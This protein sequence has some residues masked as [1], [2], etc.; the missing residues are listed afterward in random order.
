MTV[1]V[2]TFLRRGRTRLAALREDLTR[3][4]W[5]MAAVY[6]LAGFLLSA[7][8]LLGGP[9]PLAMALCGGATG[10]RSLAIALGSVAGSWAFWGSAGTESMV[11]AAIGCAAGLFLGKKRLSADCPWLIPGVLGA[12]VAVTGLVFQHFG[13][14]TGD[15]GSYLLTIVL[16]VGA[17]RLFA[18]A[19]KQP[20]AVTDWLI[21]GSAVLA[22]AQIV[23]LPGINLGCVAGGLLAVWGAFPGALLAGFALDLARISRVSMTAVLAL[24][25]LGRFVPKGNGWVRGTG[26]GLAYLLVA[27]L[28]GIWD[29]WP[30][31]CLALGGLLARCLP[32]KAR[33]LP[34]RGEIGVA[35]VRLEAAAQALGECGRLLSDGVEDTVDEAAL[36]EQCRTRACGDCPNRKGCGLDAL[37]ADLLHREIGDTGEL[38]LGCK[39]PGRLTLELRRSREQ[40]RA[41]EGRRRQMAECRDALAWQYDF[42]ARYLQNQSDLLRNR[43][44]RQR[45][46]FCP[47]VAVCSAGR[48]RANGDRCVWFSG[49]QLRCFVV[50]CD[51][52]G[53]GSLAAREGQAAADILRRLLEAGFPGEEAIKMLNSLLILRGCAG[54]VTVDL[55]EIQLATGHVTL[56]KWGA[57]PSWVVT[58]A[59]A[60]KVG[61]AGPPPGLSVAQAGEKV[62]RLP[63]GR[64]DSLV[65]V[66][67]GV[68][69]AAYFGREADFAHLPP[70]ELAAQLLQAGQPG[71]DDATAVVVRLEAS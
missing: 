26:P 52:M 11:W 25:W 58:P 33:Y 23:P 24:G 2:E 45:Q 37:P 35:Q 69:A 30:G 21:Q 50:L 6:A 38:G 40:L 12:G 64:G 55:A 16:A 1:T 14:R 27:G 18:A 46:K 9:V 49:P 53:T 42:L 57:A 3:R 56:Y 39:K 41:L 70:G 54:A 17:G 32:P 63:L 20:T 22:L 13:L 61:T 48:E 15:F 36:L 60:K 71:Q 43:G 31:V 44:R 51:G 10:W 34:R 62:E 68:E 67:D 59:G 4:W 47:Q 8:A 19:G 28:S 7:G 66:S 5:A 29:P 65:L